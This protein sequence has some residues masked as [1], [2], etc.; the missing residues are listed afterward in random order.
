MSK[1]G[2]LHVSLLVLLTLCTPATAQAGETRTEATDPHFQIAPGYLNRS[3]LPDS[4]MLLGPPPDK[5]SA[6]LARDEEARQATFRLRGAA[7][8]KLAIQDA[9]LVFPKPAENFSCAL[10]VPIDESDTPR[11][12]GLMKKLM[13]DAGLST[14]GVKNKYERRRPFV[15]HEESTCTPDQ[16]AILRDDGSYPSGH[17]A[18]GWAWAL[19]LSEVAPDR[20]DELLA[21]G[22]AF[23]QSRVV[24]DAHWQSDVDGG[25]IMG[26]A[27]I[28]R[29][30]ADA[31]FLE[32]LRE[33]RAEVESART[34]G[35]KPIQDC[36][37][38]AAALA[39]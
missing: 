25:R 23:G 33:A 28:S 16:E 5:G 18:A 1:A 19:A 36:A 35:L 4:L 13:S 20:S 21:R 3:D 24:C 12:Y 27:V 14:Y 29:L 11:L 2:T 30:H 26:A 15:V 34:K 39:Q 32:D 31:A 9:D 17:T 37:A 22:L 7:R 6:A 8:W 38:E 10:G